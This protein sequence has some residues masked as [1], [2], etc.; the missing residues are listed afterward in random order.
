MTFPRHRC[1]ISVGFRGYKLASLSSRPTANVCSSI[2]H[3]NSSLFRYP[4]NTQ[5]QASSKNAVANSNIPPTP[6]T[7]AEHIQCMSQITPIVI[8]MSKLAGFL[9]ASE[10]LSSYSGGRVRRRFISSDDAE[11]GK[12]EQRLHHL[13]PNEH[14]G[15]TI[16]PQ[17]GLG[18]GWEKYY[19]G[20]PVD[21]PRRKF[22][23]K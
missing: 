18:R 23:V 22:K 13:R 4:L 15:G 3:S 10:S 5:M 12:V 9:K 17:V 1:S 21:S 6:F 20:T 8:G 16:N 7:E 14:K 2:S 11:D 19:Q